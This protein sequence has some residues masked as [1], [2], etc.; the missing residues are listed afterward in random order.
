[1]LTPEEIGDL[2]V[3]LR[4]EGK[5]LEGDGFSHVGNVKGAVKR[6]CVQLESLQLLLAS[7]P[8]EEKAKETKGEQYANPA[9]YGEYGQNVPGCECKRVFESLY[10]RRNSKR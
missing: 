3:R 4:A 8:A 5:A 2:I 9:C 1:M 10:A 6:V 7:P